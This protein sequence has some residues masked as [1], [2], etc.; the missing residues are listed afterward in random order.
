M[1]L[2]LALGVAFA[3]IVMIADAQA[4]RNTR[5]FVR[6]GGGADLSI[7]ANEDGWVSRAE[8]QAA[9]ERMFA[10]LDTNHD[11]RLAPEDH[12]AESVFEFHVSGDDLEGGESAEARREVRVEIERAHREAA[13]ALRRAEVEVRRAERQAEAAERHAEAAERMAEEAE[14]RGDRVI[15]IRNGEQVEWEG[16]EGEPMIAPLPPIP[17]VPPVPGAP[18]LLMAFASSEEADR[19]GDGALSREEFV[20]QQ[21]RFFDASDANGDGRVRFNFDLP[22]PPPAPAP[23][24]PP[25]RR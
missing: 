2:A 3:A 12:R 14:R 15:I 5:V 21:L 9:A 10:E 18:M 8:A 20:A 4:D 11:G 17:P 16:H 1:R 13:E 25:A 7:D 22:E 24:A 19:N 6:H 23:P